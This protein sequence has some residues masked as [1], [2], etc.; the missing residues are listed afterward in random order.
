MNN[1]VEFEII[2]FQLE[3][4][5][6]E[7]FCEELK[8][9]LFHPAWEVRHGASSAL[10]EIIKLHGGSA[11]KLKDT[12]VTE[13]CLFKIQNIL[14]SGARTVKYISSNKKIVIT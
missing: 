1:F 6:F 10:R 9:E 11:G 2:F 13:V 3:E 12:P 5:S 7:S 4:W 8:L 14:N